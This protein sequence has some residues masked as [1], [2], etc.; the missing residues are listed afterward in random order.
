MVFC[1]S[2]RLVIKKTGFRN[3]NIR[4]NTISFK[5][6]HLDVYQYWDYIYL[7]KKLQSFY[8]LI[9]KNKITLKYIKLV[10]IIFF[11]WK[12]L[13]QNIDFN[14]YFSKWPFDLQFLINYS[15][16][17]FNSRHFEFLLMCLTIWPSQKILDDIALTSKDQ[18]LCKFSCSFSLLSRIH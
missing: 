14:H 18:F 13:F 1:L 6:W 9:I 8:I 2:E 12:D 17:N 10:K 4:S 15:V 11:V 7:Y 5:I 3:I 16:F